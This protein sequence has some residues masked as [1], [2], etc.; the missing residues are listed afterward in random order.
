[1]LPDRLHQRTQQ[2]RR[3]AH[4]VRHGGAVEINAVARIDHAL[5]M[6]RQTI[7]VFR[8]GNVGE[9]ARARPTAL[10]RKRRFRPI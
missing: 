4:P 2:R 10:D 3:A 1:M 9:K 6:Q 7:G 5:A 8:N